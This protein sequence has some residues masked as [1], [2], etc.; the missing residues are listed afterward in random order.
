VQRYCFFLIW[1]NFFEKKCKYF[2]FSRFLPSNRTYFLHFLPLLHH[3]RTLSPSRR[4]SIR[5]SIY[6]SFHLPFH[7]S[8]L[9]PFFSSLSFIYCA[10]CYPAL[11][12]PLR[13]D[14]I[15]TCVFLRATIAKSALLPRYYRVISGTFYSL[16]IAALLRNTVSLYLFIY[17][18]TRTRS[19]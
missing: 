17:M 9:F 15:P 18:R 16:V 7:L 4:L 2:S 14:L 8:I 1:P 6:L 5:L 19:F 3:S 11:L 12:C 13:R 10:G